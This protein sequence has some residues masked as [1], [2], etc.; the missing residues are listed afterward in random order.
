[1]LHFLFLISSI[2]LPNSN[3]AKSGLVY[4][5]ST[6]DNEIKITADLSDGKGEKVA[7]VVLEGSKDIY[8]ETVG[9]KSKYVFSV[10]PSKTTLLEVRKDAKNPP[11]IRLSVN[12]ENSNKQL[13]SDD[14]GLKINQMDAFLSVVGLPINN[15]KVS[16]L[17]TRWS[18]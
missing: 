12:P 8:A 6:P 13:A 1:M 16:C 5:C 14:E 11:L 3:A 2:F 10:N 18:Y 15:T 7:V 4:I 9:K 17:E